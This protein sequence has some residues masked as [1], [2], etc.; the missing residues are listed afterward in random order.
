MTAEVSVLIGKTAAFAP[1]GRC[2][3][4]LDGYR[5]AIRRRTG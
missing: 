1:L 5:E 3:G 2:T 4:N